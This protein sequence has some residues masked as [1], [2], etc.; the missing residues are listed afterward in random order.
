MNELGRLRKYVSP[1]HEIP[2]QR[3]DVMLLRFFKCEIRKFH[4]I[5]LK[6]IDRRLGQNAPCST[7]KVN[8]T[9]VCKTVLATLDQN[10]LRMTPKT[11]KN[12]I[13]LFPE[14]AVVERASE[15]GTEEHEG[16]RARPGRPRRTQG[17]NRTP[18]LQ[19]G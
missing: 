8:E 3:G 17:E 4:S 2:P 14:P 19:Q 5:S 6:V 15:R 9:I 18:A 11:Y 16:T 7:E 13:L 10:L 12:K 1:S